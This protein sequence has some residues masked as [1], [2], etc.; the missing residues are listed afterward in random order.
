MARSSTFLHIAQRHPNAGLSEIPS[1]N[2]IGQATVT[3]PPNSGQSDWRL[4]PPIRIVRPSAEE[5]GTQCGERALELS[6][7]GVR[8]NR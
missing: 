2:L 3:E 1:D 5:P 8:E 4:G 7:C 6:G